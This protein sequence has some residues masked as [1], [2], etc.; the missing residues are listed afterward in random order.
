MTTGAPNV[1]LGTKWPSIMSMC[2][3]SQWASKI[4]EHAA[5]RLAKSAERIDGAMMAGGDM[6][7][8][9]A[10]QRADEGRPSDRVAAGRRNVNWPTVYKAQRTFRHQDDALVGSQ[11]QLQ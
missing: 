3:Q 7:M 4:E 9:A 10:G 8:L 1:I 6:L 2:A 11:S 5:P